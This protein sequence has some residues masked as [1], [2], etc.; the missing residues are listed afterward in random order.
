MQRHADQKSALLGM[1]FSGNAGI[2]NARRTTSRIVGM[3]RKTSV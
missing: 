1:P 3:P 2:P